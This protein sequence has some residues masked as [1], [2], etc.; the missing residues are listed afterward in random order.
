MPP[1]GVKMKLV[2]AAGAAGMKPLFAPLIE[3]TSGVHCLGLDFSFEIAPK[4]ELLV[5]HFFDLQLYSKMC[6]NIRK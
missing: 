6:Y 4:G 2:S 3:H 5:S 1:V